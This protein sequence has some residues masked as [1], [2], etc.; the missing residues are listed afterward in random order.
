M[1]DK[2]LILLTNDDGISSPF[3]TK[4]KDHLS[5]IANIIVVVPDNDMSGSSHS[6]SLKKPLYINKIA[7][8]II[9]VNGTPADC[10]HVALNHILDEKPDLVLSGVN[11]GC[12]LGDDVLYSGTIAAAFESF[13]KGVPSIA[14]S[15]VSFDIKHYDTSLYYV[16]LILEKILRNK[17]QIR[18]VL[19]VNIPDIPLNEV[20]GIKATKLGRRSA[21]SMSKD[22]VKAPF[23]WPNKSPSPVSYESGSD[24][25]AIEDNFVS[26]TPLQIDMTCYDSISETSDLIQA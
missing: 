23:F 24:F 21:P 22:S 4:I 18:N 10:I 6:I 13:T 1:R 11:I 17:I 12:N 20:E 2:P 15:A 3:V 16:R 8:D 5:D 25:A 19:S 7:S 26:V 14:F 9:T